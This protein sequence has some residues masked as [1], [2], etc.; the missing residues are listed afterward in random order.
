ME[1]KERIVYE[2]PSAEVYTVTVES[3]L[4]QLS[5]ETKSFKLNDYEEEDA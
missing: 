5:G 4:L 1:K 2:S 3:N